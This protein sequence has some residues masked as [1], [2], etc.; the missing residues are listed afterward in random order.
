M[1]SAISD[2]QLAAALR[3][4]GVSG[5]EL[6]AQLAGISVHSATASVLVLSLDSWLTAP[7]WN[8]HSERL[9]DAAR[10]LLANP[11]ATVVLR[12]ENGRFTPQAPLPD[13]SADQ[14]PRAAAHDRRRWSGERRPYRRT[15]RG[16][17][18]GASD[19]L[20]AL[21]TIGVWTPLAA[22]MPVVRDPHAH[23]TPDS[24]LRYVGIHGEGYATFTPTRTH[25]AL[26]TIG[27]ASL[28]RVCAIADDWV[29]CSGTLVA[30]AVFGR[31]PT[32]KEAMTLRNVLVDLHVGQLE[33]RSPYGERHHLPHSPV[34]DVL[35][36]MADG[37]LRPL[38]EV[39]RP[40]PVHGDVG[41]WLEAPAD[42]GADET[43]AIRVAPE[44]LQ[45]AHPEPDEIGTIATLISRPAALAARRALP[46]LL[47][48]AARAPDDRDEQIKSIYLGR[49]LMHEFGYFATSAVW[50]VERDITE[51]LVEL[52]AIPHARLDITHGERN[53][54]GIPTFI[55]RPAPEPPPDAPAPRCVPARAHRRRNLAQ[56]NVR[57]RRRA[58]AGRLLRPAPR[59]PGATCQAADR[60]RARISALDRGGD[61]DDAGGSHELPHAA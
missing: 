4:A 15:R 45:A 55:V 50:R 29:L 43:L 8:A 44:V 22:H 6:E 41:E 52:A 14:P 33:Y 42:S 10:E 7:A 32:W 53:D 30:K 28:A 11:R 1:R 38:R 59:P 3:H 48:L 2:E 35:Q 5:A 49:P 58:A 24:P 51:D 36:L 25:L 60:L 26:A 34:L 54:L 61:P 9:R 13:G 39:W 47:R 31:R 23:Y 21:D 18:N 46:Q 16:V 56:H 20:E 27:L 37:R 19:R 57:A 40:D 17:H 12:D